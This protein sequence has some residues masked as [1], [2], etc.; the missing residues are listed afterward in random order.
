MADILYGDRLPPG[1]KKELDNLTVLR[2][3]L[4]ATMIQ[5]GT[6]R[7]AWSQYLP[8]KT[9][10]NL[11]DFKRRWAVFNDQAHDIARQEQSQ[12]CILPW[13]DEVKNGKIEKE[14]LLQ[15][16]DEMLFANL[17]VTMGGISWSL[18]F[19]AANEDVQEEIR[20]EIAQAR[21]TTEATGPGWDDYI[22]TPSSMLAA[23]VLESSRLA[24]LAAFSVPQ[25]APTER[26]VG[27]FLVPAGTNF[28]VDTH[29]LNIRNP[30]WGPDGDTYRPAR[31]LEGRKPSEMRYQFW[32]F[33]FGPRQCLGKYVV[34]LIIR[35]VVA[36]LVEGYR[37]RLTET[38]HWDKN[39]RT[40][41]KHPDTEIRCDKIEK[42]N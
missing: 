19:L 41:I 17:D 4:W 31:F 18:L 11:R 12:A 2:D 30:Y 25:A 37:L 33:G 36:Q 39:P 28:I 3:S 16:I 40:W 26:V 1:L 35:T 27:G 7:F 42:A 8:T 14:K 21:S 13:Y 10:R 15:T 38:T 9:A 20:Q 6:T 34:D 22:K 24:P 29:A 32:R 23:S 5:G